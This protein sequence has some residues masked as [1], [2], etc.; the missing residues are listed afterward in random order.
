MFGR[1]KKVTPPQP[2]AGETSSA[3]GRFAAGADPAKRE[4]IVD[5]AKRVFMEK[6]FDA[7]SM[8]DVARK[9]GVSKGTIYVYFQNKEDLFAALI[10]RER[11]KFVAVMRDVLNERD[12]PEDALQHY[13]IAFAMHLTYGDVI[14]AMRIVLGVID[15]MPS[16]ARRFFSA[17]PENA[18]TVL[19]DYIDRQ[20]AAGKLQTDDSEMAAR[21]F[22]ELCSGTYFK[23]RLFG[24]MEVPPPR[25]EI[26]RVVSSAVRMFMA[27]YGP[28]AA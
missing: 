21:Q 1:S 12:R 6:G 17:S 27:S 18:R 13:G 14:S 16:L 5:G 22:V 10:E 20:V 28:K 11:N 8:N 15:R 26:E 4:Q 24:E 9:A 2:E 3:S 7:A 19:K 23:L 25:Q